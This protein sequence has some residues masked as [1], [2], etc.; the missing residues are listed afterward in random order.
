M[1]DFG[2]GGVPRAVK[3]RRCD[4]ETDRLSREE[5]EA[6]NGPAIEISLNEPVS[7]VVF[8]SLSRQTQRDYLK[9]LSGRYGIGVD[10][11]A[12]MFCVPAAEVRRYIEARRLMLPITT[13]RVMTDGQAAAWKRFLSRPGNGG[14]AKPPGG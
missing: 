5:W 10:N 6:M 13:A 3:R 7:W 9:R 1:T 12:E 2:I 11:L 4:L 8:K 14:D